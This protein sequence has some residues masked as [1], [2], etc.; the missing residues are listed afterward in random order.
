MLSHERSISLGKTFTS[1]DSSIVVK[2]QI[3]NLQKIPAVAK[4]KKKVKIEPKRQTLLLK[5]IQKL[6]KE[7]KPSGR[8]DSQTAASA[9]DLSP[10]P[11]PENS[12]SMK[13]KKNLAMPSSIRGAGFLHIKNDSKSVV[14]EQKKEVPELS[15]GDASSQK[16]AVLNSC[17]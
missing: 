2:P 10:R 12:L 13:I 16:R 5:R 11:T 14:G 9:L 3:I 1:N 8:R 4:K 6:E 15:Q 7:N 17:T